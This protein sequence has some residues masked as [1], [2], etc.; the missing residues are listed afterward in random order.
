MCVIAQ[1]LDEV[2]AAEIVIEEES[3]KADSE[4]IE[5]GFNTL[6]IDFEA[7]DQSES[8]GTLKSMHNYFGSITPTK[9]NEYTGYFMDKNLILITAEAFSPYVIN[10][11]LTPTLYK[12]LREAEK[13]TDVLIAIEPIEQG[14]V[15][16]GGK[17]S[18][19]LPALSWN[20]I[21]LAR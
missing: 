10:E 9:Q 8:N 11:Q 3:E 16:D 4:D 21:R 7:L 20:V 17:L 14:G 5:Y 15:M 19:V 18:I 1:I 6:D 13:V 2:D 12:L